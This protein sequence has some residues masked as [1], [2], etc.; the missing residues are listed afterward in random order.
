MRDDNN[1]PVL[2]ITQSIPIDSMQSLTV[3]AERTL[4][5]NNFL[6]ENLVAFS[7]LTEREIEMLKCFANGE[8]AVECGDKL[9]VSP[10]TV[11]T[12]RKNIRKKLGTRSFQDLT[13]YARAFDLI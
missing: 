8:S 6:K 10:K 12:H 1:N 4:Q 2:M 5:E 7:K 11:E 13:K 3:K 9:F